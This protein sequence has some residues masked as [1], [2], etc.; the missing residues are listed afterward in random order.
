MIIYNKNDYNSRFFLFFMFYRIVS[1]SKKERANI[2]SYHNKKLHKYNL[3]L[4][5]PREDNLYNFAHKK[6]CPELTKAFV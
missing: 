3:V 1:E 5:P 4:L 2:V 6:L